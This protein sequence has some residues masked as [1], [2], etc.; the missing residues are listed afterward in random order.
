MHE[1]AVAESI[2]DI[3]QTEARRRSAVSI[4]RIK[5]QLGEFTTI[6]REAL[7]FAFEAMRQ[8]TIASEAVLDIEIIPTVVDCVICCAIT[9]PE[10]TLSL[11]CSQCGFPLRIISGEELRIEYIEIETE[12]ERSQWKESLSK[13]TYSML[14]S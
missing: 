13:Q 7:E 9:I 14:T 5:L 3:A 11:I 10:K 1:L 12:A 4:R 2:L 6:V 8:G